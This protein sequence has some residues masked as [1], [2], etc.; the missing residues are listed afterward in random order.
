MYAE[1]TK[2]ID[3]D[4]DA[5]WVVNVGQFRWPHGE[6][7]GVSFDVGTAYRIKM[8]DWIEGQKP[9]LQVIEDPHTSEL[10]ANPI[11]EPS[12]KISDET[13]KPVTGVGTGP[14]GSGNADDVRKQQEAAK[15][16]A[17]AEAK[18]AKDAK[19]K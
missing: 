19:T 14:E 13:G 16:K 12:P 18:A 5:V 9:I 4:K 3:K 10:P 7:E 17:E 15:A 11:I 6:R 1:N 2:V 8:D